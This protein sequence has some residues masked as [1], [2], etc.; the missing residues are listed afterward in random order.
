MSNTVDVVIVGADQAAIA[1]AT[2][3][4]RDGRSVLLVIRATRSAPARRVRQSLRRPGL[5]QG[6]VKIVT[7]VEVACVDGVNGVE[8]V[9]L[10]HLRTGRLTAFNVGLLL[11]FEE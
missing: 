3:A 10:R 11:S 8:A 1:A 2:E 5:S 6:R 4:A 7:G 9:V